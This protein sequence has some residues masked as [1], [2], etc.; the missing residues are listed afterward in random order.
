MPVRCL[1]WISFANTAR[2]LTGYYIHSAH[3]RLLCSTFV[4]LKSVRGKNISSQI[5]LNNK[6]IFFFIRP[7]NIGGI[8]P[9]PIFFLFRLLFYLVIVERPWRKRF[10]LRLEH[11]VFKPCLNKI[12]EVVYSRQHSAALWLSKELVLGAVIGLFTCQSS[13]QPAYHGLFPTHPCAIGPV[14]TLFCVTGLFSVWGGRNASY[15]GVPG[16]QKKFCFVFCKIW[17]YPLNWIHW[18]EQ[19]KISFNAKT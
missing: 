17:Q 2:I 18:K 3:E 12:P 15:L 16:S 6:I 1:R 7:N 8:S 13:W 10:F 4:S 11:R 9:R 19:I 5:V 14:N